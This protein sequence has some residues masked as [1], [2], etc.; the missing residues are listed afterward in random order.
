MKTLI[1]AAALIFA[2]SANAGFTSPPISFAALEKQPETT[3]QSEIRMAGLVA[4]PMGV[5]G[6]ALDIPAETE[7][8]VENNDKPQEAYRQVV[9]GWSWGGT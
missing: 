3:Q 1:A 7:V 8:E 9:S 4:G 6:I 5:L 2:T